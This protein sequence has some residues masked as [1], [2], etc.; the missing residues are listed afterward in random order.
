MTEKGISGSK[1]HLLLF[2]SGAWMV[3]VIIHTLVVSINFGQPVL[4]SVA[5]A[6]IFNIWLAVLGTGV[7]YMVRFTGLRSRTWQEMLFLHLSGATMVQLLWLLPLYPLFM[8]V[9]TEDEQYTSFL[10]DS[11]TIRVITGVIL[12]IIIASLSY[13]LINIKKLREQEIRQS[14]LQNLLKDS[15]LN[16]LRFQINPHFL[17]NSL[18][19]VSSLIM[20]RP[21]EA[22]KMVIRLSEFMRYSLDSSS[23]VMSTLAEEIK[24]CSDYL[25][26]EKV[27]FGDRLI[28]E[29]VVEKFILDFPVPAMMLQPLAENAVKHGLDH[30][31][32]G[33]VVTIKAALKGSALLLEVI[34]PFDNTTVGK[35]KGTGTGLK[36]IRER[37]LKI[38]GSNDLLKI[39]RENNIFHVTVN[40]P[41]YGKEDQVSDN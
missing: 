19:A 38:Y 41:H 27:R 33:I 10:N 12:Y 4:N 21:A 30:A 28:V 2:Y 18:N 32:E 31:E 17:F 11:L 40:L 35:Q 7:W 22:N 13:L 25:E 36:N 29:T 6:L 16:L 1:K 34:N 14:E 8:I 3:L 37:L 5:E 24:H 15:E 20:T 23:K 26:I 9:F 39:N